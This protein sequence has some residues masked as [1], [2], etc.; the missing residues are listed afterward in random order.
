MKTKNWIPVLC[1]ISLIFAAACGKMSPDEVAVRLYE[2]MRDNNPKAIQANCT[3][4][5]ASVYLLF[6]PMAAKAMEGAQ[7]KAIDT[8]VDGDIATVTIEICE[9]DGRKRTEDLTLV[10]VKGVWKAAA[11]KQ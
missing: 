7:I 9:K 3:E 1:T 8:Q 5:A 11:K 6:A 10:K 2:G 4:A